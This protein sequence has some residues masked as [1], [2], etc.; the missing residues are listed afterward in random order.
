MFA[1]GR[2][3]WQRRTSP[4]TGRRSF[5]PRLSPTLERWRR[6]TAWRPLLDRPAQ[7]G[8][9]HYMEDRLRHR[10]APESRIAQLNL[11]AA[12]VGTLTSNVPRAFHVT[13]VT[14]S[15][16]ENA[17]CGQPDRCRMRSDEVVRIDGWGASGGAAVRKSHSRVARHAPSF[18]AALRPGSII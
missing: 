3:A 16:R 11:T 8:R 15:L 6:P 14:G 1:A 17:S 4:Q 9:A 13:Y 10:L 7:P 12:T 5:V 18:S 2:G